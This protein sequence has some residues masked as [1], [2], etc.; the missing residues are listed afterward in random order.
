MWDAREVVSIPTG[1]IQNNGLGIGEAAQ[2]DFAEE[3]GKATFWDATGGTY[4]NGDATYDP[5]EAAAIQYTY[6][7]KFGCLTMPYRGIL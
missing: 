2:K 5:V 4:R 3:F 6:H 1:S 7:H